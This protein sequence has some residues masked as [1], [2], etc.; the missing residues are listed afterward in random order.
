MSVLGTLVSLFPALVVGLAVASALWLLA[1]PGVAPLLALVFVLYGLPPL[2][3]RLHEWR[4]PLRE[5]GSR[6]VGK[7]Y[8]PW[9]GGHQLQLVYLSFPGLERG[10][11][12]VPGLFSAWLRLWGARVGRG[13]YWTPHFE[14][15]DRSLVEIGNGV[16]FGHRAGV[17]PHVIKPR[18]DN[19]LLLVKRVRIDD[20]AFVGA[21]S[22]LGPG[23]HVHAGAIVEA[24]QHVYPNTEITPEASR[25]A[26]R[27]TARARA[28]ARR[29]KAEA[30]PAAAPADA[31][32]ADD[33]AQ[34]PGEDA[35]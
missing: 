8:S 17:Y 16:I 31:P 35:P 28:E 11:R 22:V 27:E 9:Y 15:S 12:L 13:V 25:E 30:E 32:P 14:I 19:L 33:P 10:L 7:A 23:V 3:F 6:L 26:M 18:R 5:G 29:A 4:F 24:G 2:A 20:G 21:G 34:E 1:D